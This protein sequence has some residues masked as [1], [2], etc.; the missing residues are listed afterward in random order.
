M[1]VRDGERDL[2][3]HTE[4]VK[5]G[6]MHSACLWGKLSCMLPGSCSYILSYVHGFTPDVYRFDGRYS[7]K[8]G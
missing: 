8:S 1:C 6:R 5:S 4:G 7:T 3:A 2:S